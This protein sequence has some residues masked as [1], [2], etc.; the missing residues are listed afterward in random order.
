VESAGWRE[1]EVC[2]WSLN[3]NPPYAAAMPQR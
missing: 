3:G 1:P 2:L